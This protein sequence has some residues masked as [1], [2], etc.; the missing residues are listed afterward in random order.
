M[1]SMGEV[2]NQASRANPP[3]A[4]P[5]IVKATNQ[6][7]PTNRAISALLLLEGPST[8]PTRAPVHRRSR[9]AT[10]AIAKLITISI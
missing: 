8:Q 1:V 5:A 10:M 3:M 2:P 9:P 4:P 6:P 7:T